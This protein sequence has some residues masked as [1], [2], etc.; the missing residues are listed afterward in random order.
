MA[1]AVGRKVFIVDNWEDALT[2]SGEENSTKT[3]KDTSNGLG[4]DIRVEDAG[5][6]S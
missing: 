3:A 5:G 1:D 6:A 2:P 4:I